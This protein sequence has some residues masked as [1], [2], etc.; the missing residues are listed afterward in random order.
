MARLSFFHV[1]HILLTG[2]FLF[3]SAGE[4]T[5]AQTDEGTQSDGEE[6]AEDPAAAPTDPKNEDPLRPPLKLIEKKYHSEFSHRLSE[7]NGYEYIR[8]EISE[9]GDDEFTLH[10]FLRNDSK[11]MFEFLAP[12]NLKY[13]PCEAKDNDSVVKWWA[14]TG[15]FGVDDKYIYAKDSVRKEEQLKLIAELQGVEYLD[16]TVITPES[17]LGGRLS[18]S[19][20]SALGDLKD[21]SNDME[22]VEEPEDKFDGESEQNRVGKTFGVAAEIGLGIAPFPTAGFLANYY[23]KRNHVVELAYVSGSLS[24]FAIDLSWSLISARYKYFIGN[25]FYVN[26]GLG[27]RQFVFKDKFETLFGAA[28]NIDA[29]LKSTSLGVEFTIGNQWQWDNFTL[30]TDWI[31]IFV[32]VSSNSD[33][34]YLVNG[35]EPEEAK[36]LNDSSESL[37]KTPNYELLRFYLGVTF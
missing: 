22:E 7:L 13:Q 26:S 32:P 12:L 27:Y 19:Q 15:R 21:S 14:Q 18:C 6:K 10:L 35:Q 25:S 34:K 9:S 11:T 36:D 31:G 20:I 16:K 8:N 23:I 3:Y 33:D 1:K 17:Y 5:I 4:T 37:G 30:G 24:V 29:E 2:L 28:D